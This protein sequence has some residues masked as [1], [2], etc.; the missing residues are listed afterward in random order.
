[1]TSDKDPHEKL[2]QEEQNDVDKL[3]RQLDDIAMSLDHS[4]SRAILQ[5]ERASSSCLPD[6]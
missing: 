4:L 3:I 6:T 5:R 2:M 1:M